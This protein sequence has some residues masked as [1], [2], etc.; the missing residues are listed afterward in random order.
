[1]AQDLRELF[2]KERKENK[3]PMKEGHEARFLSKLEEEIPVKKKS[4]SFIWLRIAASIMV[5][6]GLG[7]YFFSVSDGVDVDSNPKVVENETSK[8][9][10]NTI[11]LGDLSPDLKKIESYYVTNI[12]LELSD[13]EF[14]GD[15]KG[16]IDGYMERLGELDK[17]YGRLNKDLNEFGP[18]DQ[19]IE[20]LIKNLQLRL[21]LLQKLK[22]KLNQLKSSKNEQESSNII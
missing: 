4:G 18:N 10:I 7:I 13:L 1:M 19:T 20:A 11:S 22:S 8:Q 17:E 16:V 2:A 15:N 9:Q 12:S 14:T 21:Q 6:L 3:Y 5:I